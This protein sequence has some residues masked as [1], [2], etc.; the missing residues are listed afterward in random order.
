VRS[1]ER[2]ANCIIGAGNYEQSGA[3]SD[4]N[5]GGN[6]GGGGGAVAGDVNIQ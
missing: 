6:G 1:L 2:D 4:L 5:G 3:A